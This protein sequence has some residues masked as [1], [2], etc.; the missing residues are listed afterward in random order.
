MG[1]AVPS[2]S[3]TGGA[4]SDDPGEHDADPRAADRASP[5]GA[6]VSAKAP[7]KAVGPKA[8]AKAKTVV[9]PPPGGP[10]SSTDPPVGG[11]VDDDVEV[12]VPKAKGKGSEGK[13]SRPRRKKRELYIPAIGGGE[14]FFDE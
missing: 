7:P 3:V 12:V 14:A 2:I 9:A 11:D 10:G 1:G 6:I 4:H 13:G 8:V 5:S